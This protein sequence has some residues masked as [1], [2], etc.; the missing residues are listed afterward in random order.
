MSLF[1]P[2]GKRLYLNAQEREAFMKAAEEEEPQ[3]MIFCHLVHFTGCRPSEGLE[4]TP[5]RILFGEKAIVFRTLKKREFDKNGNR[6]KPQYRSVPV[7]ERLLSEVNLTFHVRKRLRNK[8][9]RNKPLWTMSRPTA[10]RMVKR[11]M[12]RA[13]IEGPQATTKGLR[14]GLG[15]ALAQAKTPATVIR[16]VLGHYDTKTTEIYTKAVGEEMRGFVEE[17]W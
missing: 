4:L 3:H 7:P 17:T 11:V 6:R 8:R 1:D 15:I 9:E 16:D 2:K 13:G 14:H 10:W 12:D 5:E